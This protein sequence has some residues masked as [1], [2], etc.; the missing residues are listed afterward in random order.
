M[1]SIATAVADVPMTIDL[2]AFIGAELVDRKESGKLRPWVA[3]RVQGM[4]FAKRLQ[5]VHDTVDLDD[6][7]YTLSD[8]HLKAVHECGNF[9]SFNLWADGVKKL[10]NANFC[11]ER[12]CPMC[13]WRLSL[14][15]MAN[16][17]RI[18]SS[19]LGRQPKGQFVFLTL[20]EKNCEF[21][22]LHSVMVEQSKALYRLSNYKAFKTAVLGYVRTTE[23]TVNR[24][25]MTFHPHIHMLLMVKPSYFKKGYIKKDA[26]I[27][28]WR[29]A[30]Q[31]DYD[32]SVGVERVKPSVKD[33]SLVAAAKEVAKYQVKPAC[34]LTDNFSQDV[35]IIDKLREGIFR[36]RLL[37]YGGL[38]AECREELKISEDD[39]AQ[40]LVNVDDDEHDKDH[41]KKAIIA[42]I[43]YTWSARAQNYFGSEVLLPEKEK[44]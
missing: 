18:L 27:A 33:A 5:A 2:D 15:N 44:M 9:L 31:L 30:R 39:D 6:R 24:R 23:I 10:G 41:P 32:P 1:T 26:W 20:T 14:K 11:R 42:S 34:Y 12:L 13:A 16:L 28:M 4:E 19:A 40:D 7:R 21:D 29:K 36:S 3:R 17:S 43:V 38:F 25:T 35:E 22:D 37:S 8:Q